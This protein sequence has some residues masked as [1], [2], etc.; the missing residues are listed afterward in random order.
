VDGGVWANNPIGVAAIEAVG[1]LNWPADRLKILSIGTI[2]DVK[3]PPR[4]KGK[5][6]MATS[7]TRLFMAGQSHSALGTAKIMTSDLHDRKAIWRI[8]QTAPEGRYSLDNAS[9]IA[10]MKD[11][12]VTEAREQLPELRRHFFDKPAAAFVP[13][14]RLRHPGRAAEEHS[15]RQTPHRLR[16]QVARPPYRSGAWQKVCL[17]WTSNKTSGRSGDSTGELR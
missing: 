12:A 6:P 14:H 13:F 4:W 2:N 17:T 16:L 1:M 10:E 9:R 8:D 3:A 15:D 5:L 11:R 7:A